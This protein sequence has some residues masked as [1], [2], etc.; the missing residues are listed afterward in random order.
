MRQS[1]FQLL[2]M[3]ALL[4]A[5]VSSGS[6]NIIVALKGVFYLLFKVKVQLLGLSLVVPVET[7]MPHLYPLMVTL[8]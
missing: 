3:L 6:V 5:S 7:R 4:L 1:T 2:T 8:T